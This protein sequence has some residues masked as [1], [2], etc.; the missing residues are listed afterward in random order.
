MGDPP[1][2]PDPIL[3]KVLSL[4]ESPQSVE[5]PEFM[6]QFAAM[7]AK[8]TASISGLKD[9]MAKRNELLSLI[10]EMGLIF[11]QLCV[12][13]GKRE[14]TDSILNKLS[15]LTGTME[16][17]NTQVHEIAKKSYADVARKGGLQPTPT[18]VLT[19]SGK[20]V[21]PEPM[22]AIIITPITPTEKATCEDVRNT[23]LTKVNPNQLGVK[24]EKIF[25][26]GT[27]GI[28]IVT[29]HLDEAAI[30]NDVL[31]QIGLKYEVQGR[32]RPR[33]AVYGVPS[34]VSAEIIKE[35]ISNMMEGE[36]KN[37]FDVK[38]KFGPRG[39]HY[40]HWILEA[41]PD[42][43]KAL[44]TQERV[45]IGWSSCIIK[46]HVRI[47]QCFKCQ[48]FGHLQTRCGGEPAC[49]HCGGK[50]ES[51][52]CDRKNDPPACVNCLRVG[53]RETEHGAMSNKCQVYI[54]RTRELISNTDYG[55]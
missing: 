15:E 37:D 26:S 28:K 40:S 33:M 34:E 4:L 2:P 1:D 23:L 35:E 24:P 19:Q 14:Q 50:H 18:K 20:S 10:E 31:K 41:S 43:R 49:G 47:I 3:E 12:L 45:Y 42:V 32:L 21:Q 39:K 25:K 9:S 38:F 29:K 13:H 46:D 7:K 51:R 53:N 44:L 5:L 17:V 6:S 22:K 8:T 16:N 54:K 27:C 11:Y 48:K 52:N 30:D 36:Y 55:Q